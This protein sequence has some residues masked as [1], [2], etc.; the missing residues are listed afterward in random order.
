[1]SSLRLLL[2]RHGQTESNVNVV[3]DSLPPGPPLTQLGRQQAAELAERLAAE[4]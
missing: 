4:R 3:L 2:V 1:V